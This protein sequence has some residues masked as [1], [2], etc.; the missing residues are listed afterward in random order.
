MQFLSDHW[1]ILLLTWPLWGPVLMLLLYFV[2]IQHE[3]GGLWRVCEAVAII[4]YPYDALLQYTLFQFYFWEIAPRGESTISM[5]LGRI[6]TRSD[7]RGIWARRLAWLLN[8]M[9]PKGVHVPME[10]THD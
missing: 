6:V 9:S 8:W 2:Y 7:W 10:V 5:R 1:I 3:R 4:G